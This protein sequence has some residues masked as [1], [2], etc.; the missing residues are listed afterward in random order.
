MDNHL[1]KRGAIIDNI[2]YIKSDDQVTG[3]FLNLYN[4]T[5]KNKKYLKIVRDLKK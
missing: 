4:Y 3:V 1:K 5:I 2:D